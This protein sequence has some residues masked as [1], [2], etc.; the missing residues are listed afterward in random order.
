MSSNKCI[1]YISKYFA[2]PN[3]G[4]VGARVYWLANELS[5]LGHKCHVICSDSTHV[6]SAPKLKTKYKKK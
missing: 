1:W 5:K 3:K 4:R 6:A 2:L